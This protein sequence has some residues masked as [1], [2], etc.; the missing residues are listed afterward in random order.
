MEK[1]IALLL[2]LALAGGLCACGGYLGSE[3][4]LEEDPISVNEQDAVAAALA[5][6]DARAVEYTLRE[7]GAMGEPGAVELSWQQAANLADRL[8]TGL[9][10]ERTEGDKLL[11][12]YTPADYYEDGR[13]RFDADIH[14]PDAE[15][16]FC[17]WLDSITGK[18]LEVSWDEE[19]F[20]ENFWAEFGVNPNDMEKIASAIESGSVE[21]EAFGEDWDAGY[22]AAAA[23]R[24]AWL[25]DGAAGY[26]QSV[27]VLLVG[28]AAEWKYNGFQW[29]GNLYDLVQ[30]I[31]SADGTTPETTPLPIF[32]AKVGGDTYA[33]ILGG[34]PAQLTHFICISQAAGTPQDPVFIPFEGEAEQQRNQVEEA[35]STFDRRISV[36]E[37][38]ASER[39]GE[40]AN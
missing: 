14:M 33:I 24:N 39:R 31:Y 30:W 2:A 22:Q 27:S 34:P 8:F 9:G 15:G 40:K 37:S 7:T 29:P 19:N 35:V 10:G 23:E 4:V 12:G 32:T 13:P 36:L 25:A 20:E 26:V 3:P 18:V 6:D 38:P 17:C 28:E 5:A 21:P 1:H 11:L 16:G